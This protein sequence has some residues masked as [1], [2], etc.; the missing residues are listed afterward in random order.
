MHA[1]VGGSLYCAK[2]YNKA[3]PPL[4]QRSIEALGKFFPNG[5]PED[6][7]QKKEQGNTERHR[8][9]LGS[10]ESKKGAHRGKR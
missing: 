9:L 5:H 3:A 1:P 2:K 7:D 4:L 8:E 10:Y 6:N